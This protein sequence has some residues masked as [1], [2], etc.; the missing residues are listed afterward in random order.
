MNSFRFIHTADIH[1]DSPLKG[2]SGYAALAAERIRTAT[3]QAFENLIEEAVTRAV[4]FVV[5]AGDLYDGDWRDY[6][7][8]LFFIRQMARLAKVNIP[9]Y[10]L[11]G[12]HDAESQITRQLSLPDGVFTF[13]SRKPQTFTLPKLGVA[14]HGQSFKVRDVT[15]NLMRAYPAPV[16]GAFNIGVLH[17]ALEGREGHENYAPCT[18]QELVA[19][20]Y[21]YWALGHIHQPA[22]VRERQPAIVFPGN[23]QGRHVRE[24]G[25]RG[26]TLVSVVD[27]EVQQ[28]TPLFTDVVRWSVID[29][30]LEDCKSMPEVFDR[31][32]NA[33]RASVAEEAEGRLLAC[34]I[35]LSGRT[36]LHASLLTRGEQLTEEARGIA[37]AIGEDQAWIERVQV[38]TLPLRQQVD[39]VV[40]ADA[41]S[42]LNQL[43]RE[44]SSD[45]ELLFKLRTDLG[46]LIHKL[47]AEIREDSEDPVL[48]AALHDDYPDLVKQVSDYLFARLSDPEK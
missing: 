2:L 35:R 46:D 9:V 7:T 40:P 1:L 19:K 38:A 32:Q 31:M 16:R 14:L 30:S 21:D 48:K 34:R 8:G 43:L 11:H 36:Q 29:V 18:V 45:G 17:T 12:N 15:D 37:L 22:V 10:L 24:A 28:L 33:I 3:R 23:L 42:D 20:G 13:S 25:A 5:I 39:T 47:P 41:W 27:G 26:A 6:H 44:A 4:D